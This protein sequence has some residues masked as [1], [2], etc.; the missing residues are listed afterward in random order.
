MQ[1]LMNTFLKILVLKVKK[2]KG[3]VILTSGLLSVLLARGPES[4]TFLIKSI[5][6]HV[7]LKYTRSN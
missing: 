7:H 1:F 4:N 5:S 3:I 2:K 6:M